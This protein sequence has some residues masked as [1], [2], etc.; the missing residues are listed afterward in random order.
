LGTE[1]PKSR[2]NGKKVTGVMTAATD[3]RAFRIAGARRGNVT[4][5][6]FYRPRPGVAGGAFFLRRS[7]REEPKGQEFLLAFGSC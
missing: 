7:K 3:E 1:S 6:Y 4:L 5:D 2:L